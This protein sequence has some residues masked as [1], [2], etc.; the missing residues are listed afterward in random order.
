MVDLISL[1]EPGLE[2]LQLLAL[3]PGFKLRCFSEDTDPLA[4]VELVKDRKLGFDC[5]CLLA[6]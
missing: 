2:D 6:L 1:L 4:N 5:D 3:L